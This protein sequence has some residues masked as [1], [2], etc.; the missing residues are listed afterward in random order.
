MQE[1]VK[2]TLTMI[3]T[4]NAM[5]TN[6]IPKCQHQHSLYVQQFI[7]DDIIKSMTWIKFLEGTLGS[8]KSL[9]IKYLTNYL[10]NYLTNQ[11]KKVLILA[12]SVVVIKLSP[13]TKIVHAQYKIP[14]WGYLYILVKPNNTL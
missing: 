9:F 12:T 5:T 13:T 8:G 2:N 10:I 1:Q 6:L 4:K 14:I 7:F 3:S 11:G